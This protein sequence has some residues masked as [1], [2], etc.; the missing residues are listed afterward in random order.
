M[1]SR[2]SSTRYSRHPRPRVAG[3]ISGGPP[4]VCSLSFFFLGRTTVLLWPFLVV[5]RMWA[6]LPFV[7]IAPSPTLGCSLL[8][9]FPQFVA[10]RTN[11]T[12]F[13]Q[14][15]SFCWDTTL[16]FFDIQVLDTFVAGS[17]LDQSFFSNRHILTI[18]IL[19]KPGC[20][21]VSSGTHTTQ[22]TTHILHTHPLHSTRI[23]SAAR[24]DRG[25]TVDQLQ[26][27]SFLP[28]FSRR[29]RTTRFA[30]QHHNSLK[31]ACDPTFERTGI[32]D[33]GSPGKVKI[34]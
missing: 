5:V 1:R 2:N 3:L 11:F 26:L 31:R 6:L 21:T 7:D 33:E 20:F 8:L 24:L 16:P 27:I 14:S 13:T 25:L 17:N 28:S 32:T 10:T 4:P 9:R 22:N 12:T 18:P 30:N 34:T 15:F 23:E 19:Q 29:R